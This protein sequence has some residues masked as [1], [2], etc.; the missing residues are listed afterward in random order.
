MNARIEFGHVAGFESIVME[1]SRIRAVIVPEL[2]GRV[3][4]L[5]D[6]VL[7]RQWIWHREDVPLVR[8][9][10][11]SSYDEVWAGGWEQLFPNDAAGEFQGRLLPDHGEWWTMSWEASAAR[12]GGDAVVR[13]KG[14]TASRRAAC[15][16]EFRLPDDSNLLSVSYSIRSEETEAFHFLFKEHLPVLI[17]PYCKLVIPGG[18]VLP[19]DPAFGNLLV[20][21]P[22]PFDWPARGAGGSPLGLT[23]IP[24]PSSRTREF[25]YVTNLPAGWCGVDDLDRQA[26]LRFHFDRAQLPYLWLFLTYG[27]WQDCYTAVLE[28]CSTLPKDLEEALRRGQTPSL[29]AGGIFQTTV[30]VRLGGLP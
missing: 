25:V 22:G 5:E 11:G 9:A 1:N 2:G 18:K 29:P 13:L 20:G 24:P 21:E 15:E 16:K 30:G 12:E 7:Q 23:R 4:E 27:G 17:T 26:S 28:P 10:P 14:T 8:T 6:R 3:W 19:V